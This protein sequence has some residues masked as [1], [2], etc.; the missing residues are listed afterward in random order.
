VAAH[1][2]CS[3]KPLLQDK[4]L[5]LS[6]I[7]PGIEFVSAVSTLTTCQPTVKLIRRMIRVCTALRGNSS[8]SLNHGPLKP[9][10][11]H[12][13]P[14]HPTHGACCSSHLLGFQS[15]SMACIAVITPVNC[16]QGGAGGQQQ[17]SIPWRL[18]SQHITLQHSTAQHSTAEGTARHGTARHG[19]ARHGTARHGTAR[20]GGMAQHTW[21]CACVTEQYSTPSG[22]RRPVHLSVQLL[23][24]SQH[25][26]K[27]QLKL[28]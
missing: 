28:V 6:A 14:P 8:S 9:L 16:A 2:S 21:H 4:V 12:E 11:G 19:T 3:H 5:H 25:A 18:V 13:S 17:H 1:A 22:T 20:H 7:H 27:A 24:H 23:H 26:A 10:F 15:T